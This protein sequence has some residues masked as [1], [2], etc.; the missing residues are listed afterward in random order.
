MY[1]SELDHNEY[2]INL[3]PAHKRINFIE[4]HIKHFESPF[5][6]KPFLLTIEQKAIAETLFGY[7]YFDTEYNKWFRRFQE[8]LLLSL[9]KMVRHHF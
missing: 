4:K 3:K 8:V 2:R 1:V 9:V 6:G 7:Q 5:A